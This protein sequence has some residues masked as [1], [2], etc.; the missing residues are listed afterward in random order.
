LESEQEETCFIPFRCPVCGW[1]LPFYPLNLVHLCST[2]GRAWQEKGGT[3]HEI[4]YSVVK[5]KN[6][7]KGQTTFLPFWTLTVSLT[8]ATERV[9]NMDEF[10]SYFPLPR[11]IDREREKER[12][13]KFY[14]PAF[15]IKNIPALNKLSTILTHNQPESLYIEK[16]A[17]LEH[18]MDNVFL[19]LTE[20]KEMAQILLFSFIPTNSRKAKSFVSQAQI[21][22]LHEQ[23]EWYPFVEENSYL[24]EENTG[25][26]IH[27][28]AINS[29]D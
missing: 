11:L 20:A 4:D 15:R 13:V 9:S 18:N 19:S 25:Y 29:K 16:A 7:S 24:K 22:F 14:I 23:L 27:K 5:G 17:L 6:N 10:Y 28:N 8:T 12:K 3:Y 2:C 21:D 26:A 1:E